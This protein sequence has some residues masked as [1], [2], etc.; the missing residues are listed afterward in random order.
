MCHPTRICS[1]A[2]VDAISV[3]RASACACASVQEGGGFNLDAGLQDSVDVTL[4]DSI[5]SQ[6]TAIGG[7]E[8]VSC[9]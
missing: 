4:T 2:H 6:C 9:S 7:A 5:I 3:W 8:A 1:H